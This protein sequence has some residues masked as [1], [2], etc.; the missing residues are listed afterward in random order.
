[1]KTTSWALIAIA[2]VLCVSAC[3]SGQKSASKTEGGLT[4]A[5][6]NASV[7]IYPS[8]IWSGAAAYDDSAT[9]TL[10]SFIDERTTGEVVISS[11]QIPAVN[12]QFGVDRARWE[13][14]ADAMRRH[15]ATHP[16]KTQLGFWTV[17]VFVPGSKEITE[18]HAILFDGAGQIRRR[19][20]ID[21]FSK[22]VYSTDEATQ[23]IIQTVRDREAIYAPKKP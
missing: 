9:R 12:T 10:A 13:T 3:S 20:S 14:A 22:R 17:Y 18:T 15:L 5:V 1:M 8:L 23:L 11:E 21:Q 7:T 2:W 4:E 16:L 19:V 6:Q